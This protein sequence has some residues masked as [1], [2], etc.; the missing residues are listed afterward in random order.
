M[1]RSPL[2]ALAWCCLLPAIAAFGLA[3]GGDEAP[4]P[5]TLGIDGGRI[6]GATPVDASPD[7]FVR[8]PDP[9]LPPADTEVVLPYFGGA[10]TLEFNVDANLRRLD[11]HFSVDTT[12][13]FSEEID[14]MQS[15]LDG[16]IIPA[17]REQVP[18][19]AIGVSRFEDFPSLPYGEQFDTPFQLLTGITTDPA[20][21]GAAV[22]RLDQP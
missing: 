9:V 15:D 21:V 6:D 3:C 13:S 18:D 14:A 11:V 10:V 17:L 19:I 2:H 22:A 4:P 12:G 16:R 8:G 1:R 5:P 20:R 7:A